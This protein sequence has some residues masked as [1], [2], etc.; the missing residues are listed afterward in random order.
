MADSNQGRCLIFPS[1]VTKADP[2]DLASWTPGDTLSPS[3]PVA[4]DHIHADRKLQYS[5]LFGKCS[6][7]WA[8]GALFDSTPGGKCG[9]V[10]QTN[11][12]GDE[13]LQFF[14]L[15]A[16]LETKHKLETFVTRHLK[17][18]VPGIEIERLAIILCDQCGYQISERELQAII[19]RI[20]T[21]YSA[22]MRSNST[23][24]NRRMSLTNCLLARW[25]TRLRRLKRSTLKHLFMKARKPRETST[26]TCATTAKTNSS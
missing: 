14:Y 12:D 7:P 23:F 21:T 16:S 13:S 25:K 9:I 22:E 2:A 20:E 10:R 1:Q 19:R 5:D 3:R 4:K 6:S 8:D 15:D 18:S 24:L 11:G 17:R 26:F